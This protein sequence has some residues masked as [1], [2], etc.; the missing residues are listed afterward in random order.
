M[1]SIFSH[2]GNIDKNYTEIPSYLSLN[3]YHQGKMLEKTREKEPFSIWWG[4]KS[5]QES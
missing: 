5:T 4:C 2:Q 3:I 1:F